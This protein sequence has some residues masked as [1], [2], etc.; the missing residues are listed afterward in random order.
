MK[1]F[2]NRKLT[3]ADGEYILHHIVEYLYQISDDLEVRLA[4]PDESDE[5]KTASIIR[6]DESDEG[7]AYIVCGP[8]TP[9]EFC[10]AIATCRKLLM[11][12][13]Q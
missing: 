9:C 7:I 3:N 6:G 11:E 1:R 13:M 2:P 4:K 5:R 12:V 8:G 10:Q